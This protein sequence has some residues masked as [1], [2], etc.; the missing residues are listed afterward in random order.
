MK[1]LTFAMVL[2]RMSA[3]PKILLLCQRL[4]ATV[5]YLSAAD[6]QVNI[7]LSAPQHASHRFAPQLLRIV[8]V[9]ELREL[10]AVGVQPADDTAGKPRQL[11]YTA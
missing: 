4:G 11:R 3:L 5:T 9:M 1:V 2:R 8:D 10:H 6:R 7:V